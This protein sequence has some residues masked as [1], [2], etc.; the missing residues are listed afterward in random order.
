MIMD[1]GDV[2]PGLNED[3]TFA[4]ARPAEWMAGFMTSFLAANMVDK[5]AQWMPI[6]VMIWIGTTLGFA[7]LRKKFPDEERGVRN[8]AMVT[9]G[10]EPPG[11][12]APSKLQ[13]LWSGAPIKAVKDD[14]LYAQLGLDELRDRP[15]Q[16]ARRPG[17]T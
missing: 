10:F 17:R 13:P 4:G 3:W 14:C 8:I 5:P 12:P 6:L 1:S 7:L 16:D 9:F 11:I 2:I 15:S